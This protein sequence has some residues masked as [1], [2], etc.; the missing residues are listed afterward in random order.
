MH[1]ALVVFRLLEEDAEERRAEDALSCESIQGLEVLWYISLS[2]Y[3][4][5][6]RGRFVV[7][8]DEQARFIPFIHWVNT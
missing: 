8:W 6:I 4:Y 3:I 2:F 1:M 5:C 7:T